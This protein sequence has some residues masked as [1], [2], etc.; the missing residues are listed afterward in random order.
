MIKKIKLNQLVGATLVELL[1]TFIIIG[2]LSI[3]VYVMWSTTTISLRNE[4]DVIARDI[5]YTRNLSMTENS[6]Y[7][8][9]LTNSSQYRILTSSGTAITVPSTWDQ[10]TATLPSGYTL[11]T[12]NY[13]VFDGKG[14]P[15]LS[16]TA[17]GSGTAITSNLTL[18]LT[19]DSLTVQIVITPE[20]G[21]IYTN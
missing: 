11:T 6:R 5:E 12:S 17:T 20:T 18:T 21:R 9:D 15:Y 7:R 3:G 14:T 10:T 19:A 13:L 2:I 16:T 8:V 1:I 4:A